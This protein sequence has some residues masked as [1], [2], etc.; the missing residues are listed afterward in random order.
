ML[1]GRLISLFLDRD[2]KIIR[3]YLSV[4]LAV[5]IL[6]TVGT[7]I[8]ANYVDLSFPDSDKLRISTVSPSQSRPRTYSEIRSVLDGEIGAS[9]LTT[10]EAGN[11]GKS[12]LDDE[13]ITGSTFSQASRV[14]LDPCKLPTHE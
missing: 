7:S 2:N 14:R 9:S 5:I 12:V 4:S 1:F 13:I 6:A 8:V 10:I 11:S 3:D